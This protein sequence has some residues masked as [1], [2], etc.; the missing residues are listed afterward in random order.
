MS[1]TPTQI[2]SDAAAESVETGT[3]ERLATIDVLITAIMH[4][5]ADALAVFTNRQR[6]LQPLIWVATIA[7]DNKARAYIY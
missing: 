2:Q 1:S 7:V 5:A 4:T 3:V 6:T